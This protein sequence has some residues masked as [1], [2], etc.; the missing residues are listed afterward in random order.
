MLNASISTSAHAQT[1]SEAEVVALRA[2]ISELT[3]TLGQLSD[4]L[5][6]LEGHSTAAP[7]AVTAAAKP[8]TTEPLSGGGALS[9]A[10]ALPPGPTD[11]SLKAG[12]AIQIAASNSGGTASIAVGSSASSPNLTL[13]GTGNATAGAWNLTLSSPLSKG[14]SLTSLATL[15]KMGDGTKLAASYTFFTKRVRWGLDDPQVISI[16]KTAVAHC[17]ANPANASSA[18][19]AKCD[20]GVNG[21]KGSDVDAFV[22]QNVSANDHDTYEA[23]FFPSG[24]AFA[25]GAEGSVGYGNYSYL[26]TTSLKPIDTG[27]MPI[28][29]KIF[30]S[31]LPD[32]AAQVFTLSFE[33][34]YAFKA[35][36]TGAVCSASS[37]AFF[38]CAAGVVGQPQRDDSYL[39]ALE[40][41]QGF[42]TPF[43]PFIKS[44]A[45]A[46]QLTYDAHDN[47]GAIDVPIYLV[48]DASGNLLGGL[49]FG[50]STGTHDFV[51][52]VF[53]GSTF[54]LLPGLSQ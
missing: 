43:L 47:V 40:F 13:Q 6:K 53:V 17:K 4:R 23:A 34:Q 30:V 1:D 33:Y 39:T 7:P 38:S 9:R 10:L 32:N 26:T 51:T 18:A 31:L 14:D 35:N 37:S 20:D 24:P 11:H 3:N 54:S 16:L 36:K 19:Q 12:S 45:I 2:K 49:R 41:R 52:G 28:G 29:A 21:A 42:S 22:A 15:D 27:R 25:L 8:V 44:I 48:P 46:P 50:Y 5:S